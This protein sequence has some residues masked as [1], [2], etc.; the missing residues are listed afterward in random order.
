MVRVK[1]ANFNNATVEYNED[2]VSE[3]KTTLHKTGKNLHK[4][5]MV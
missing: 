2:A 1:T 5:K 3:V 4:M